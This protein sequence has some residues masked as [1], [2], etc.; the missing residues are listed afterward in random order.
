MKNLDT[1]IDRLLKSLGITRT[2]VANG[3]RRIGK[4][5]NSEELVVTEPTEAEVKTAQPEYEI[6]ALY[7]FSAKHPRSS[8][9]EL[10]PKSTRL[11]GDVAF[12][13]EEG[14][15]VFLSWGRLQAARKRYPTAAAQASA[16][17]ERTA[18]ETG[19]KLDGTPEIRSVRIQNHDAIYTHA[20]MFSERW[21]FPFGVRRVAEETYTLHVQ[22]EDSQRYYI[23]Y[24]SA[25]PEI[26]EEV[27][28][29]FEPIMSSFRCHLL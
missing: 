24:A 8:Y 9:L 29:L 23:V 25:R 13:L 6:V 28:R 2:R 27:G 16:S 18:K 14:F 12:H 26:S 21:L 19:R 4:E 17:I 22:C 1:L 15:K 7:G 11:R 10:N 20:K 3:P 5:A